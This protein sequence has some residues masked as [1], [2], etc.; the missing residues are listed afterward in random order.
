VDPYLDLIIFSFKNGKIMLQSPVARTRASADSG[1]VESSEKA[2]TKGVEAVDE[3]LAHGTRRSR[4]QNIATLRSSFQQ[5]KHAA[6][7]LCANGAGSYLG[8]GDRA[9]VDPQAAWRS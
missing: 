5:D 3:S 2:K 7:T 1:E 9:R 8:V 4:G 6:A